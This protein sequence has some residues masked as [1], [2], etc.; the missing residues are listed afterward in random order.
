MRNCAM[1]CLDGGLSGGLR[2]LSQFGN[3][4]GF[5]KR[6]FTQRTGDEKRRQWP[7]FFVEGATDRVGEQ[8]EMKL[9]L[10]DN[11]LLEQGAQDRVRGV[12]VMH[13]RA[14]AIDHP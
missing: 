3:G 9:I 4:G 7:A 13:A 8:A 10:T 1:E 11:A 14:A 5:P 2:L 12:A 6:R